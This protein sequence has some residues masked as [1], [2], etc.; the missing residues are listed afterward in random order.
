MDILGGGRA[1]MARMR[2]TNQILEVAEESIARVLR[3]ESRCN[4][5]RAILC[6]GENL[7][8][9]VPFAFYHKTRAVFWYL[10]LRRLE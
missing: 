8:S 6:F 1:I 5:V 10:F 3:E 4:W 2:R 7:Y 9:E